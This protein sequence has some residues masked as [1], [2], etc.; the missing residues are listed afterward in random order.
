MKQK[1]SVNL[2]FTFKKEERLSSKKL[3]DELFNSGS[4]FYLQPL[5]VLLLEKKIESTFP[6][7]ILITVSAKNFPSAVDRN[8][9][10]R[11]IRESFRLNKHLLY[12]GLNFKNKKLLI[13]IIYSSK[14]IEPFSL[15]EEKVVASLQKIISL[16]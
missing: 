3:I 1:S 4:S 5:K 11:L 15:I 6:A 12:D 8:K 10:K 7:Q 9:I 2:R 16:Q 14:K 13:A